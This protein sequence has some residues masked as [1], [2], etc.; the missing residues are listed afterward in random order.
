[1]A[2]HNFGQ[3]EMAGSLPEFL[4]QF[5]ATSRR[6]ESGADALTGQGWPADWSCRR[7]RH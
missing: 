3:A 7:S 4:H 1:M 5:V 2:A 6:E